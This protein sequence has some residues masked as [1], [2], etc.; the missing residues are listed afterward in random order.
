VEIGTIHT[1]PCY[2]KEIGTEFRIVLPKR[3]KTSSFA[4]ENCFTRHKASKSLTLLIPH[5]TDCGHFVAASGTQWD[6]N[7]SMLWRR[8]SM[9]FMDWKIQLFADVMRL[10]NFEG[11]VPLEGDI[12]RQSWER[13]AVPTVDGILNYIRLQQGLRLHKAPRNARPAHT[14]AGFLLA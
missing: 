10:G 12:L 11:C 2:S 7:A 1:A 3:K 13:G 8:T 14:P 6:G 5:C 4:G 9:D